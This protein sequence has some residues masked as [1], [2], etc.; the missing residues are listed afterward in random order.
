MVGQCFFYDTPPNGEH[1]FV[2]LADSL[3]SE[4]FI[5]VNITE[6]HDESDATCELFQGEHPNLTKP[7]SV[8]GYGFA[9]ELPLRLIQRLI[10]RQSLPSMKPDILKRIQNAALCDESRMKKGFQE[11]IQAQL[12]SDL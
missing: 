7:V 1:L 3:T 8:V 2:I 12:D 5:C 6:K 10:A 4:G 11:A 9:R